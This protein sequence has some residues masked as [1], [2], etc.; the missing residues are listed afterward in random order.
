MRPGKITAAIGLA[1]AAIIMLS[2]VLHHTTEDIVYLWVLWAG[3]GLIV[4]GYTIEAMRNRPQRNSTAPDTNM[5]KFREAHKKT[6]DQMKRQRPRAVME[7]VASQ[8]KV[9]KVRPRTV[10]PDPLGPEYQRE[11]EETI[12]P[13]STVHRDPGGRI[14][15]IEPPEEN[16]QAK[17]PPKHPNTHAIE[18]TAPRPHTQMM[19]VHAMD[20]SVRVSDETSD[21]IGGWLTTDDGISR[22]AWNKGVP[23]PVILEE[24][25]QRIRDITADRDRLLKKL[26]KIEERLTPEQWAQNSRNRNL[27]LETLYE[28][29]Q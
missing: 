21:K 16:W 29:D 7:D 27:L 12:R 24:R 23:G 26:K 18:G 19:I 8:R 5:D 6:M 15:C 2:I 4:T 9:E 13:G 1:G 20:P 22:L 17:V 14:L 3:I 11:L 10:Q 28:G 25:D